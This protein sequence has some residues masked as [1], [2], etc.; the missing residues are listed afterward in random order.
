M[1][2]F[3]KRRSSNSSTP[4]DLAAS[5]RAGGASAEQALDIIQATI[6]GAIRTGGKAAVDT[7]IDVG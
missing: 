2:G 3:K 1:F 4:D 6:G 7:F 5:L